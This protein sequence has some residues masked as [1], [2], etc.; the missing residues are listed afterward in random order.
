M[1]GTL[2]EFN[3][4][5]DAEQYFQFFELPYD[6]KVV[7]INRLHILK[8]FSNSIGQI[9]ITGLSEAEELAEYRKALI[10]AYELFL[11]SSG[12]EQKLFKVFNEKPQNI[13]LLRDLTLK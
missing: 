3:Q 4:L 7:N 6:A 10:N 5:T 11:A 12:I 13:V 1:S 8:Q 2:A 9:D